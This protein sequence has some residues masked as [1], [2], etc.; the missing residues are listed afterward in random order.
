MLQL[1]DIHGRGGHVIFL[2]RHLHWCPCF[3]TRGVLC[4]SL[5]YVLSVLLRAVSAPTGCSLLYF[6][7]WGI[8]CL[9]CYGW[10]QLSRR[11][12]THAHHINV[13][14]QKTLRIIVQSVV[15]LRN[16]FQKIFIGVMVE[17]HCYW[18]YT[19]CAQNITPASLEI[20]I[21]CLPWFCIPS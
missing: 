3:F 9:A 11:K 13:S 10:H 19:F 15:W 12:G 17:C 4:G 1:V 20:Y 16:A 6:F 14:C 18:R 8:F 5:L 21:L 7:S 2:V